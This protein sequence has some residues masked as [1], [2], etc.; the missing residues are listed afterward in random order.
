MTIN[1]AVANIISKTTTYRFVIVT[2]AISILLHKKYTVYLTWILTSV[3]LYI[4]VWTWQRLY[5]NPNPNPE[6]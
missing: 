5:A 2:G 1:Q 6:T 3:F 4:F